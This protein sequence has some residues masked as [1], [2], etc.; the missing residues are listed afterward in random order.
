MQLAI[1][2]LVGRS[3]RSTDTDDVILN[4]AGALF[5]YALFVGARAASRALRPEASRPAAGERAP[6]QDQGAPG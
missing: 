5:G 3:F 2:A 6:D 1:S 4:T